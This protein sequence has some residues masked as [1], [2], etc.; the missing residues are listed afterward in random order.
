MKHLKA[1][2]QKFWSK[3]S[4]LVSSVKPT[5]SYRFT[6]LASYSSRGRDTWPEG[7][8]LTYSPGG[9]EL[10][11]FRSDICEEVV[12]EV[13]RGQVELALIVELP[14]IVLTYRFGQSIP[15]DDVPYSWHMQPAS[16][17]VVPSVGIFTRGT[18]L[19][20]DHTGRC[21]GWNHSRPTGSNSVTQFH[22]FAPRRDPRPGINGV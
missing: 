6:E 18:R 16:W 2:E 22:P 20:L 1:I 19:A 13:R 7:G 10:I 14:L 12:N 3:T 5:C 17:R 15:W 9:V 8:Q 11:L 4:L 21:R